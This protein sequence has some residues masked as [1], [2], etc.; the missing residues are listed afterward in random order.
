MYFH[1]HE[2]LFLNSRVEFVFHRFLSFV[3]SDS[4][5]ILDKFLPFFQNIHPSSPKIIGVVIIKTTTKIRI[6]IFKNQVLWTILQ[7]ELIPRQ[8]VPFHAVRL[9][10]LGDLSVVHNSHKIVAYRTS[11]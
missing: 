7:W 8:S 10:L 9:L 1:G 11:K 5:P 4:K 3:G 2:M 6:V